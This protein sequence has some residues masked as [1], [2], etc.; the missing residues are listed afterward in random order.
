MFHDEDTATNRDLILKV[1]LDEE[2]LNFELT[3]KIK[4]SCFFSLD[5]K[6]V[7]VLKDYLASILKNKILS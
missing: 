5:K 2:S 7:G 4:D 1:D 6:E 3:D